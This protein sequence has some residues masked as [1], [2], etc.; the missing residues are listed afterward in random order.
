[1]VQ[2]W[3]AHLVSEP[4]WCSGWGDAGGGCPDMVRTPSQKTRGAQFEISNLENGIQKSVCTCLVSPSA[5]A[6]RS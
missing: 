1:M 3:L 2:Q 5:P 4:G 6:V